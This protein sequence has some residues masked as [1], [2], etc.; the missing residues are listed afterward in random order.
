MGEEFK[1]P[2]DVM[3]HLSAI[4]AARESPTFHGGNVKMRCEVTAAV[5]VYN[6]FRHLGDCLSSLGWG[7][8]SIPF[9]LVMAENGSVDGTQLVLRDL[10]KDSVTRQYW[11]GETD[12]R[13]IK[14]VEVPQDDCYPVEGRARYR[15]NIRACLQEMIGHVKTE[16]VLLLDA[17]VEVPIGGARTMLETLKAYSDIG[18]C[19]ITYDP[20]PGHVQHGLA[21]MRT[22]QAARYIGSLPMKPRKT[23]VGYVYP[24]MCKLLEE[25]IVSDGLK[26]EPLDPLSARHGRLEL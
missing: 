14:I 17:D 8:Q 11:I 2:R 1:I 24:C 22:E 6:A 9:R 3:D 12:F 18:W 10:M 20:N 13:D 25:M 5:P 15:Y 7:K 26:S 16:F 19:G 4:I 21:M 23:P